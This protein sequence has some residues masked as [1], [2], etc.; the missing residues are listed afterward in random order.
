MRKAENRERVEGRIYQHDLSIKQVQNQ[1]SKNYGKDF[2][3][4]N[5]EVA[6]DED[7]L[8]VIPV[9]FTYVT[10]QTASGQQNRTY[11]VLKKIIEEGKTIVGVGKDEAQKV[12]IDTALALNDFYTQDDQL[13]SVKTN[14]G[15]FV[16]LINELAEE[17]ERNTF[18]VDMV[19]N[20]VSRVEKDEE[21]NIEADYVVVKG[22]V[23]NFRNDLLPV[24]LVVKNAAGMKYFEELGASNAEPVYTRVWGKIVCETKTTVVTEESAFGEAAVKT[25]E[26]KSKEWVITGTAKVPHDFG[27][28]NIL[29]A[30][31]LTEAM[32]NRNTMLAET[33][34]RSEEYRAQRAAQSA[35]APAQTGAKPTTAK[36]GTFNF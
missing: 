20:N 28:E 12:R 3:S 22:A 31:E 6:V 36:S 29:T 25:Y 2:I 33:K 7:C 23:F 26:R 16:T 9:H 35:A 8:N 21:K 1:S 13:V 27:D 32:Q 4:G 15:G 24:E 18:S 19:I 10:E 11:G 17:P 14:E 34:K 30:E 5:L